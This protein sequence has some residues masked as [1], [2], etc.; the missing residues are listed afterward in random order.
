MTHGK[1]TAAYMADGYARATGRPG[2]CMP[3]CI[4]TA[5]L[6]AGLRDAH[7]S[8]TPLIAITGGAY[9]HTRDRHTY[10]QVE[11][12]PLFKPV[13][14]YS[15]D[16]GDITRL[17]DMLRQAF[18]AAT[19][20]T[21]GPV[22]IQLP[23]HMGEFDAQEGDFEVMPKERFGQTPPFRPEPDAQSVA[24]VACI[25]EAAKRPIIVAVGGVRTSGAGAELIALAEKLAIPVAT[26]MNAKDTIPGDH[27]LSA[28]IP[29]LYCRKSASR[30]VLEAD[31]VFFV[32]SH[33]GS[34]VTFEW[35]VPKAGTPVVQLDID[36]SELGRHYPNKA[37]IQG[38]AKV[39]LARLILE[40]DGS[41]QRLGGA[42][43]K[44]GAGMVR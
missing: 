30:A 40:A 20:G 17:P 5:Y 44:P 28:G 27:P 15:A 22:Y 12:L 16:V 26:S 33:T 6:A 43:A 7:L 32:G 1:K 2:I 41:A 23:G 36:A 29:G 42:G 37:S 39:S 34:Q 8:C 13:T 11:D 38:D 31:L 25:L 24:D 18:R 9:S 14:K 19:T 10:Q 21:P 35:R 4:G 3:Q